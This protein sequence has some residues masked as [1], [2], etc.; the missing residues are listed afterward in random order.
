MPMDAAV[1]VYTA[2]SP[3]S[4]IS[5][6]TRG[7]SRSATPGREGRVTAREDGVAPAGDPEG[8][9]DPRAFGV[10]EVEHPERFRLLVGDDVGAGA[11][12]AGGVEALAAADAGEGAGDAG[13]VR[14][15]DV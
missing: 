3:A 5:A 13:P 14:V 6:R 7:R 9:G 1:Q 10:A 12:E 11:I 2:P 4:G 15:A 8:A